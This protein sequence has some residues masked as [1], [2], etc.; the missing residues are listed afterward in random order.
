MKTVIVMGVARSGTS[1]ASGLLHTIGV[2]MNPVD[3]PGFQNPKG[4][5]E[6]SNFIGLTTT[7]CKEKRNGTLEKAS[8]T[9]KA[10]I[11]ELLH[12]RTKQNRE[13]GNT[14]WGWKSA[15]THVGFGMFVPHLRNPYLVVNFRNPL[16]NAKSWKLHYKVNYNEEASIEKALQVVSDNL[17][18][19]VGA[20][21]AYPHIPRHY[22]TYE[23]IKSNPVAEAKKMAAF[24]DTEF[25]EEIQEKVE[26]FIVPEYSTLTRPVPKGERK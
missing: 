12:K 15:L 17:K 10:S 22:V 19:L 16:Q 26:K 23:G 1:M 4:S 14:M 5:F 3:N 24:L 21:A 11:K 25:T 20:L 13:A 18:E 6:D 9:I 8:P 7:I 2:N